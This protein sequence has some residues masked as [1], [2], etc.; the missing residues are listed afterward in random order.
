MHQTRPI[1]PWKI[2]EVRAYLS[3]RF[4]GSR[5]ED[6]PRGGLSHLFSVTQ[7]GIDPHQ[8]QHHHLV[9]TRH[10]FDRFAGQSTIREALAAQDLGRSLERAGEGTLELY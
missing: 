8:H 4:P 2:E 10:F 9:V 3:R 7:P 6:H 5:L 1:E